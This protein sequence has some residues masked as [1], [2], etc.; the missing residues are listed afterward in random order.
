LYAWTTY[1][2]PNWGP[3]PLSTPCCAAIIQIDTCHAHLKPANA[4]HLLRWQ[5][6]SDD[7]F[8]AQLRIT[9]VIRDPC[10]APSVVGCSTPRLA[11]ACFLDFRIPGRNPPGFFPVP[12]GLVDASPRK[13]RTESESA[14]VGSGCLQRCRCGRDGARGFV[15]H[16]V[17]QAYER[18]R[19]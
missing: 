12:S 2:S 11:S 13:V 16:L 9:S 15:L 10:L 19:S 18:P 5:T 8:V 6:C 7:T 4:L 14:G 3:S 17:S 1:P